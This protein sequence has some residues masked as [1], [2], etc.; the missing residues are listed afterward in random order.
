M[1]DLSVSKDRANITAIYRNGKKIHGE[2]FL[3]T[4]TESHHGHQKVSDLL[5]SDKNFLPISIRDENRVEFVN[6]NQLLIVEGELSTEEDEEKLEMGLFHIEKV[7]LFFVNEDS[8]E[9]AMLSEVPKERS[10]LSDCLNM[11]QK[12]INMIKDGRY[13]YINKRLLLKVEGIFDEKKEETPATEEE[14]AANEN[15]GPIGE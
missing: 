8:I 9:G 5:E 14:P 4:C 7:R 6:K 1:D 13:M 12:F 3:A 15:E 10:R 2:V 11:D